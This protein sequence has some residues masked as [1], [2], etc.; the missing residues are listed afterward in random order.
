MVACKQWSNLLIE[1][2]A[3]DSV[4]FSVVVQVELGL[5][6]DIG[7]DMWWSRCIVLLMGLL[8]FEVL[9]EL[10]VF[11]AFDGL[12]GLLVCLLVQNMMTLVLAPSMSIVVTLFLILKPPLIYAVFFF[13]D[14]ALFHFNRILSAIA[15]LYY[16]SILWILFFWISVVRS[17]QFPAHQ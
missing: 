15:S 9:W 16:L 1:E 7:L 10:L 17:H 2:F 12:F 13:L 6:H 4:M 11:V 14:S 3:W 8:V 5:D